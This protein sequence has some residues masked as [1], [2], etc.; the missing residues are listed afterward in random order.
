MFNPAFL[1]C[2]EHS[3]NT[4]ASTHRAVASGVKGG[5]YYR[6]LRLSFLFT[7]PANRKR[8][9]RAQFSTGAVLFCAHSALA[10]RCVSTCL[11][12]ESDSSY[13]RTDKYI[14]HYVVIREYPRN[15]LSV[16]S[17]ARNRMC[18]IISDALCLKGTAPNLLEQS[19][20]LM[21][22]QEHERKKITRCSW[23]NYFVVLTIINPF[24]PKMIQT[25]DKKKL[26]VGKHYSLFS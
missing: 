16:N 7:K 19:E 21:L 6:G 10:E 4:I 12:T 5:D 9:E 2:R 23:L 26:L 18:I 25:P 20:S 3:S 24:K 15:K 17:L 14:Q 22:I 1:D 11:N 13:S 8:C